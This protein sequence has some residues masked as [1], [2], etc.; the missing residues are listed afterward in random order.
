MG[1]RSARAFLANFNRNGFSLD[2]RIPHHK[3]SVELSSVEYDTIGYC[4]AEGTS[5]EG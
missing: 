1:L 5:Q 2:I 4:N 3:L